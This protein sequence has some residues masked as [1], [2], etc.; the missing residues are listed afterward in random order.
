MGPEGRVASEDRTVHRV[1][2]AEGAQKVCIG[3]HRSETEVV[4]GVPQAVGHTG[5]P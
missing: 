2:Q 4:A 3:D 5:L 1:A